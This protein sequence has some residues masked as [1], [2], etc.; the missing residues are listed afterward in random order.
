VRPWLVL[1]SCADSEAGIVFRLPESSF[2]TGGWCLGASCDTNLS[3][4]GLCAR[5]SRGGAGFV[6][7]GRPLPVCLVVGVCASFHSG[8]LLGVG[9]GVLLG[10]VWGVSVAQGGCCSLTQAL[11]CVGGRVCPVWHVCVCL[12]AVCFVWP[13]YPSAREQFLGSFG[14]CTGSGA[15]SRGAL[16]GASVFRGL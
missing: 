11:L 13:S 14:F 10:W 15:E 4:S 2:V 1:F 16:V 5:V 3:G 7:W 12:Y 8:A 6:P 9:W